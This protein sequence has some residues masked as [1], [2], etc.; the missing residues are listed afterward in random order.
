MQRYYN[1]RYRKPNFLTTTNKASVIK[2]SHKP[3]YQSCKLKCYL[4]PLSSSL[5]SIFQDNFADSIRYLVVLQYQ[6][7]SDAD[8]NGAIKEHC[9]QVE[10]Q[11]AISKL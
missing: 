2:L 9:Y 8:C 4:S 11:T 1:A 5:C 10:P 7:E 3:R 6:K